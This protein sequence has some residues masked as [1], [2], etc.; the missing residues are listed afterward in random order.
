MTQFRTAFDK[1]PTRV[2]IPSPSQ[3]DEKVP[4]LLQKLSHRFIGMAWRTVRPV[5]TRLSTQH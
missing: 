2:P 4:T 1:K 5:L 3:R